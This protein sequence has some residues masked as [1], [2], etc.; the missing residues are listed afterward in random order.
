MTTTNQPTTWP[1]ATQLTST[2]LFADLPDTILPDLEA[3][4]E[5]VT[6]QANQTLFQQGD[7]GD[8]MY[9][10]IEGQLNIQLEDDDG[11]PNVVAKLRP[12]SPV[13]EMALLTGQKRIATAIA[14]TEAQLIRFSKNGF[15]RLVE[16]YPKLMTRFTQVVLP[17]IR[18][19]QLTAALNH[20]F[21]DLDIN[22]VSRLQKES[23]W[24]QVAHGETVFR[25]G[26]PADGMYIVINGRLKVV[27][28]QE[29]GDEQQI[30][31]VIP[32]E[33][34]GE[35]ALFSDE[36]RSAT[37]YA[38]RDSNIIKLS[39]DLFD[40]LVQ[41]FPQAI[42]TLTRIIVRRQQNALS[43]TPIN[44]TGGL[45]FALLPAS[46]D[47]PLADFAYQLETALQ[48]YGS[49]LNL[50]AHQFDQRYGKPG[51]AQTRSS[52]PTNIAINTWLNEQEAKVKY[53]IY[54]MD[55]TWTAWG[56][57]CLAHADRILIVAKAQNDPSPSPL[58]TTATHH[59][60]ASHQE[61]ILLQP[62]NIDLPTNTRRWLQPRQVRYHH[63]IR[64]KTPAHYQR[65]A[66]RLTGNTVS[67]VL[68][69]GGA[70]SFSHAG[71][72]RALE[73]ANVEV[74]LIAGTSMGAI[75]G[76]LHAMERPFY[77]IYQTI[78]LLASPRHLFDYT[79]PIVSIFATRKVSEILR[80]KSAGACIEDLW[81]TYFCVS[82]NINQSRPYAHQS[83][84]LWR[85]V[86][87]SMAVQPIFTP[88]LINGD[89]H[90]DG[91][92]MNNFPVDL[93]RELYGSGTI[94]GVNT[95]SEKIRDYDFGD[96]IS[97][98]Q[99]LWRRLNPFATAMKV[100]TMADAADYILS[101][102]G[103]HHSKQMN[104]L[105]DVP[106]T[107]N[108]EEFELL[109]MASYEEIIERGYQAAKATLASWKL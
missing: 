76:A 51:A 13:G 90:V 66:R 25:Q 65:V 79:L 48:P 80:E 59:N 32:G 50:N 74:D 69:G 58:E 71:I 19:T 15:N 20:L 23:L 8:S 101:L 99:V 82:C 78:D 9:L 39:Q 102:N 67:L 31:E 100:P 43:D 5:L 30:G 57:R 17:R 2:P 89:L 73:E 38:I 10:L 46:P 98:W 95:S 40:D 109:D 61:L 54:Q 1:L 93:V 92:Y 6:L 75:M 96:S 107:P 4:L 106:I 72:F 12:H 104:P 56:H 36:P 63:H 55:T 64:V 108:V 3:E 33:P 88:I 18:E 34:V 21:G 52:G 35:L 14:P 41:R 83:G 49:T 77:N 70:R 91:A 7:S 26:D 87:A 37:V 85:A 28:K 94:I 44:Q 27:V 45:T 62:A 103:E 22:L 97:G 84:L 47:V 105:I 16:K 68:S 11:S 53:R 60:A 29:D 42:M 81:R 86:R 24:L